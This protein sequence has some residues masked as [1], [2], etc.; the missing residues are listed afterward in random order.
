MIKLFMNKG[1]IRFLNSKTTDL[2]WYN[3]RPNGKLKLLIHDL[4]FATFVKPPPPRTLHF[5]SNAPIKIS[6][7]TAKS[8][9]PHKDSIV[10]TIKREETIDAKV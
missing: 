5:D 8:P 10:L 4:L 7:L 1:Q 3:S 9:P 6:N 2:D